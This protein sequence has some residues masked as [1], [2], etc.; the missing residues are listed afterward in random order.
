M[1]LYTFKTCLSDIRVC[2]HVMSLKVI[3]QIRGLIEE[4]ERMGKPH[5]KIRHKYGGKFS[6]N[7]SRIN[8]DTWQ[9]RKTSVTPQRD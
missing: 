9:L 6:R 8:E 7:S 5:T 2:V 4:N 3:V 1:V